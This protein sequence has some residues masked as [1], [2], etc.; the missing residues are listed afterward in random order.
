MKT[1]K[2][3]K[4][5]Q[6]RKDLEIELIK[7]VAENTV[8]IQDIQAKENK[9]YC[10]INDNVQ[11]EMTILF[12]TFVYY[13]SIIPFCLTNH[14]IIEYNALIHYTF[15]LNNTLNPIAYGLLNP[16]FRSCGYYLFKIKLKSIIN[17]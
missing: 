14:N 17:Y 6:I 8:I 7:R 10:R 13:I 9:K 16:N 3:K 12:I 15:L 2:I 5:H 1:K 4:R 11:L